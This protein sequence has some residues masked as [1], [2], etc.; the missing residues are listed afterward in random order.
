MRIRPIVAALLS[1]SIIIAGLGGCS[2]QNGEVAQSVNGSQ[3]IEEVQSQINGETSSWGTFT[4]IFVPEGMN[5]TGGSSLDPDN[6]NLFWLQNE[7]NE[8]HYMVVQIVSDKET[9]EKS[10]ET[11]REANDSAEDVEFDI[12]EVHWK[13]VKYLYGGICDCFQVYAE[14][15]GK[16]IL[17]AG[18]W[19]HVESEDVQAVLGGLSTSTSPEQK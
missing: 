11:T 7:E 9:A 13:G 16:T 3:S 4:S 12:G 6:P 5:L 8:A 2:N 19:F 17:A 14:S 1:G 15:E 18:A 10:I